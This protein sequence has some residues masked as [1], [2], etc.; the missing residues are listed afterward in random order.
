MRFVWVFLLLPL[1]FVSAC[2]DDSSV[3][4]RRGML[5][6]FLTDKPVELKEV[7]VT[8]TD[9]EVH[10]TGGEWISF[11][12]SNDSIDL[13]TVADRQALLESAP[14]EEGKF[15]GIRLFISE[16]HIIDDNGDRCDLKI[17]SGK[18]QI[19]V[20]FNVTPTENTDIVL[21]F[22]ASKSVQVTQT[23]HNEQCIL[24]PVI[25]PV[26]VSNSE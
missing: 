22:D 17:P 20:I 11:A 24:R 4:S 5:Q 16:A 12:G 10:K 19:P 21:D 8:I 3:E 15:T 13:L 7:W 25:H 23:G 2:S 9:I 1:L 6:L 26:S 14:L 18:V